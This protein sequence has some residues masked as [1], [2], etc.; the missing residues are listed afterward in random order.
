MSHRTK[1]LLAGIAGAAFL[2]G[3]AACSK[4][5]GTEE[6]K[7]ETTTQTSSGEVKTTTESTTSGAAM[8]A[9]TT[10]KAENAAPGGGTMKTDVD[11]VVGTVTAYDPGKK[12]EVVT[13][14]K[15]SRSFR[16]D[17]NDTRASV[18]PGVAVGSRVKVT[19]SKGTEKAR[20]VT[21]K[22]ES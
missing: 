20:Q 12:I 5:P 16:L 8:E 6:R 9:N 18:D 7:T 14:E 3:A 2:A 11:T 15:K 13:A 10:T 22:L 21:V 17:A 4:S 1:T 19:E